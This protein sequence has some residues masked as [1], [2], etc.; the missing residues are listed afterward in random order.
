LVEL[1]DFVIM[2]NHIHGVI[3][4]NKPDGGE[5]N[6]WQIGGNSADRTGVV[7]VETGAV[8]VE[9]G[10]ALSLRTAP[11]NNNHHIHQ[12]LNKKQP[13]KTVIKTLAKKRYRLS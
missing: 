11:H 1:G 3:I 4:I 9:T 7:D 13:D 8:F 12:H 5:Q 2:P 10:H 6:D